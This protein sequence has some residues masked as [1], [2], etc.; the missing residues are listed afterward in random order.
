MRNLVIV[1]AGG[2]AREVYAHFKDLY[3]IVGFLEKEGYPLV[4]LEK[5]LEPEKPVRVKLSSNT[6]LEKYIAAT[7]FSLENKQAFETIH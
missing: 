2:L 1:G 7:S 4:A 3:N 6:E 5:E